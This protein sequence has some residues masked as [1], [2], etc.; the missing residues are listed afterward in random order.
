MN[1]AELQKEAHAIAEARGWYDTEPT[2]G[3]SIASI[4]AQLSEVTKAYQAPAWKGDLG[5]RYVPVLVDETGQV[6]GNKPVGTAANL[7]G[8]VIHLAATAERY[9][10]SLDP[11]ENIEDIEDWERLRWCFEGNLSFGDWMARLHWFAA[12]AFGCD[13]SNSKELVEEGLAYLVVGVQRMAAN[14][15]IDLDAAI[16]A[17]MEYYRTGPHRRVGKAL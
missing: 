6:V 4:H 8:V 15:G 11:D 16:A 17:K 3:D 9:G 10:Y 5:W 1:L 2:F 14:Y 7:S 12:E 13:V